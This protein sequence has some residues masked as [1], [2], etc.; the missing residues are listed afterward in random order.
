MNAFTLAM[1]H[2]GYI[3]VGWGSAVVMIGGYALAIARKGRKLSRQ[4]PPE[5]R[6]WS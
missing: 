4:V 6:R 2:A 3:A 5:Q 1:T